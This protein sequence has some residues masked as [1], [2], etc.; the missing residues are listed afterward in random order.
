MDAATLNPVV[1]SFLAGTFSGTCSTIFFQPLDLVKTRL[2]QNVLFAGAAGA[3][4]AGP[5]QAAGMVGVV[6][7]IIATEHGVRAL[8]TGIVP[9]I[10][11]TVPGVGIYF[12]S[13]ELLKTRFGGAANSDKKSKMMKNLILGMTARTISG[14]IM[15][16]ATVIKTRFESR[17]YNYS[18]L[19]QAFTSIYK[20]EG[21]RGLTCGLL[22]TVIRDAPYSG[23]YFM[24]YTQ[25]KDIVVM[26]SRSTSVLSVDSQLFLCKVAAGVMA[27]AITHPADVV[28]TRMQ[29]L[30]KE[31]ANLWK[32][33]A[34]V[35]AQSGIGGF[36]V[37][38]VPRMLRRTM[39]TVLAWTVYEKIVCK[40]LSSN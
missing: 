22:P 18:H 38:F 24:F 13:L 14:C 10:A 1:K 35:Y 5:Q 19:S 33:S 3:P 29:L 4:L 16:P 36:A 2:Q 9:S 34:R 32:A 23:L 26:P 37:G 12:S 7:H 6:R 40:A 27:C 11:R 15:I 21:L 8:W 31:N 28:K 20:T 17:T 30:P 39:M 25:L